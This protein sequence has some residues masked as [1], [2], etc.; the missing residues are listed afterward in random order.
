MLDHTTSERI[1]QL[2]QR[3]SV[4]EQRNCTVEADKAQVKIAAS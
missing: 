1:D 2:E 4:S 3:V